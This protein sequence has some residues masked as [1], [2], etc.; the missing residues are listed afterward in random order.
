MDR[1][2]PEE[3]DCGS[4]MRKEQVMEKAEIIRRLEELQ[5]ILKMDA[6]DYADMINAEHTESFNLTFS[7][8]YVYR[9]GVVASSIDYI[10]NN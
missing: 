10:L 8:A 6:Q 1:M 4:G 7:D 2:V 3:P 9:T 5:K